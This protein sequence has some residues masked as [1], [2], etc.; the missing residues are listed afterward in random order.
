MKHEANPIP[1]LYQIFA[2]YEWRNV[3]T[4]SRESKSL[5]GPSNVMHVGGLLQALFFMK[6]F[7]RRTDGS[8]WLF[9][10]RANQPTP[11]VPVGYTLTFASNFSV[12]D[13]WNTTIAKSKTLGN[14]KPSD[15]ELRK[16]LHREPGR[17]GK[18]SVPAPRFP[19]SQW[20]GGE[21]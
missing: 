7:D 20:H 6:Y 12:A 10:L 5:G 4:A 21:E 15:A 1:L 2:D 3:K 13:S 11:A 18:T 14:Q 16:P 19:A 9:R 8:V 17:F